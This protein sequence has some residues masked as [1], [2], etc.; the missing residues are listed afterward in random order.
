MKQI[1]PHTPSTLRFLVQ[2]I[3]TITAFLLLSTTSFA[4]T[5]LKGKALDI[6][7]QLGGGKWSIVEL[8]AS[9]CHACRQHMPSMVKFDGKLKNARILGV[10]LDGQAGIADANAF[11]KEFGIKFKNIVSNP[12][13]MNAWMMENVGEGLIGTPT[14]ILFN[15]EGKLVAAQPGMISTESLETFIKENSNKKNPTKGT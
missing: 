6:E 8:W 2:F 14:F 7:K 4:F 5:D 9:D 11:V 1:T 10:A 13:E 12:I 15:P 3:T